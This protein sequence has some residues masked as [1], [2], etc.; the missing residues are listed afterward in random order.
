MKFAHQ[1]SIQHFGEAQRVD[2]KHPH[3]TSSA[4]SGT[5]N[6]WRQLI[7]GFQWPAR[8]YVCNMFA[9]KYIVYILANLW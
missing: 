2:R 7:P 6:R 9:S 1:A 5:H 8:I 4:G 3:L